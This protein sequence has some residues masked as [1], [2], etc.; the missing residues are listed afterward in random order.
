MANRLNDH[1]MK[2][3]LVTNVMKQARGKPSALQK[4]ALEIVGNLTEIS[5][6]DVI[7]YVINEIFKTPYEEGFFELGSMISTEIVESIEDMNDAKSLF[8]SLY[9]TFVTC[10]EMSINS[11]V[12][13]TSKLEEQYFELFIQFL[14]KIDKKIMNI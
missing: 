9:N 3:N 7:R 1:N 5:K 8:E 13:I 14:E 4:Q 6:N 10:P 2:R 12:A 11:V